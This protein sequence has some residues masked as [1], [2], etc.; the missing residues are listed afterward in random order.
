MHLKFEG[1]TKLGYNRENAKSLTPETAVGQTLY[2]GIKRIHTAIGV[3]NADVR[4][5][6]E[7]PFG[8]TPEIDTQIEPMICRERDVVRFLVNQFRFA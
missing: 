3:I 1:I 7:S 8:S 2:P 6:L 5:T 4:D